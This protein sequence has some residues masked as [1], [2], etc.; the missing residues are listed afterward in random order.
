MN[1]NVYCFLFSL[2]GAL[3]MG[4]LASCSTL[5][6]A[7]N[8]GRVQSLIQALNTEPVESLMKRSS[9]P[10]LLDGEIIVRESDLESLWQNLRAARFSFSEAEIVSIQPVNSESY[11]LFGNSKDTQFF[12]KK[13][14][15]KDGA[16]AEVTTSL[17]TFY[18]ITG[19][20]TWF[21]PKIIGFTS[22]GGAL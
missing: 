14:V 15:P 17:G 5:P 10:F 13:Y 1:R 20:R 12:F 11:L 8:P 7:Q 4:S 3:I 21:T 19:G 16:I 9:R 2:M 22:K 6:V 18:I